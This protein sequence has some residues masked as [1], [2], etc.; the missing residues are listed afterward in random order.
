MC[1][2][3]TVSQISF[4][5]I[6]FLPAG[7]MFLY[8][9]IPLVWGCKIFLRRVSLTSIPGICAGVFEPPFS[10][11]WQDPEQDKG[12]AQVDINVS[13][14]IKLTRLAIK[15]SL[16]RG[17]RASVCII[18]SIGGLAGNIA[19]PLYCATKHAIVGFVKSMT[20]SEALTGVKVTTICPGLVATPL[21][22]S[23]KKEQYSFHENNAL[24][25]DD[26][27]KG[28]LDLIQKKE[29]GCGTV[30]EISLAGTRVIPE[31]NIM[32][33]SAEGTGQNE[34][35]VAAGAEALLLPI[36]EKL[37]GEMAGPKL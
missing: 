2:M 31:W 5:L 33:P 18:A 17:K 13:H 35:E 9:K 15:K 23:D 20:A 3:R 16:Q 21:F 12:Y 8:N 7:T 34:A 32:P 24:R 1:L 37:R 22:T 14:P 27:A 28:M 29:L 6:L 10:N 36:Q 4:I 30:Y 26:V 19:A 25:P 11:F